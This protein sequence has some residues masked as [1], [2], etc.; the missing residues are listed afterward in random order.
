[1]K[2]T[3]FIMIL[4]ALFAINVQ[5]QQEA[6]F[7]NY[8]FNPLNINPAYAGSRGDLSSSIIHRSQW[9]G[10]A[11][12]PTSES[13]NVHGLIKRYKLGI[14]GQVFTDKSGPVRN[15]NFQLSAAYHLKLKEKTT[16][17]FGLQGSVSSLSVAWSEIN[18]ENTNDQAYANVTSSSLV[19]DINFG[20]YLYHEKYFAG[21]SATH[22]LQSDFDLNNSGISDSKFSRHYYLTA[23]TIIKLNDDIDIRPSIMAK[24]VKA[25]PINVSLIGSLIFYKKFTV[26]IGLQSAKRIAIKGLDNTFMALA[27]YK[28]NKQF[29]IGY[30]YDAY[31]NSIGK[32]NFG[33]HE[34]MIGWD[35]NRKKRVKTET[36]FVDAHT[37]DTEQ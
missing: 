31:F 14:G 34:I 15:T 28:I 11:G 24:Y 4:S 17:S 27:E 3:I 13:F 7:S 12:A 29:R 9:V 32:Q 6:S 33:S 23:G 25:A 36:I 21:V 1:M 18:T 35:L 30:N 22:L 8:F 19:P 2:K 20:M 16:L 10:V 26:G 5:A 37:V